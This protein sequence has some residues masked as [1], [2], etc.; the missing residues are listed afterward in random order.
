[1]KLN[2]N[3]NGK[4][5]QYFQSKFKRGKQTCRICGRYNDWACRITED[6]GLAYCSHTPN[7]SNKKDNDGRYEYILKIDSKKNLQTLKE[8]TNGNP[9]Q[10]IKADA[11]RL[12]AVYSALLEALELKERHSDNLL[13]RRKLTDNDI[14]KNLY[15]SVPEYK[16]RF[17]IAN[18]LAKQFNLEGVP[19]FYLKDK[20]WCLNMTFSGFYIPYRDERGRIVGLQIRRDEY[21]EKNDKYMWL[22]SSGKQKGASSES[23]LHFVNIEAVKET[24]TLY[25][26]EGG[27]KADIIGSLSGIGLVASAGIGAI[28]AEKPFNSIFKVFPDLERIILAYD[29][30]WETNDNVRVALIRL[31]DILIERDAEI[32]IATWNRDLG[33]GLDDVLI[34][35]NFTDDVIKY[36]PAKEFQAMLSSVAVG[37]EAK[38]EIEEFPDEIVINKSSK[39]EHWQEDFEEEYKLNSTPTN[40]ENSIMLSCGDFLELDCLDAEKVL[41]GLVRGNV[42][43]MVASTNLG[44]TTLAL[45]LALSA[46]GKREFYPLFNQ[47]HTARKILY[48]DGEAT[49]AELQTDIKKMLEVFTSPQVK[50]VKEN[51]FLICDEELDDEPL[52]LVNP[53]HLQIIEQKALACQPDLI[54]VDTLSALMDMEDENDNAKIKKEVMK[55]LKRL[56][57]KTN[58]AVLIL[59]HTGKFNEGFS[60]VG[61]YKGRGASA[62]G[63][64]SRTVLTLEKVKA[65][66][67]RI[68]LSSPKSKGDKFEKTI[69][70]LDNHS[71]W[72]HIVGEVAQEKEVEKYEQVI[73]FVRKAGRLVKRKEIEKALEIASSSLTRTLAEAIEN[74]DLIQPKYGHY[75]IPNYVE[76]N[77]EIP[78]KD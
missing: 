70:E 4:K 67:N 78:M 64:L 60:S 36:I 76:Q 25:L 35:E 30:D 68:V 13:Y 41:F 15:A 21:E 20:V 40:Q 46:T 22:S 14:A 56:A 57:K 39:D 33:K 2:G 31:L 27:L 74:F 63:G 59:H 23:P 12:N 28:S 6:E 62:F 8:T 58:S 73:E 7:E 71:R 3:G 51:L 72:F 19:G 18:N 38:D 1:M 42:G 37:T 24:K 9:N 50:S 48:I 16:N 43:L 66:E 53:E 17:E 77:Q 10:I 69:L 75:S 5:K 26:T 44:K 54:I 65:K 52:D 61:A 11:D 47:N 45:N 49:K 55:P 32:D 29:M 34:S